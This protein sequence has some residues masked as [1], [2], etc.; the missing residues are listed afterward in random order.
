MEK[1]DSVDILEVRITIAAR[2]ET[3]FQ[4]LSDP[5]AFEQ[6]MGAGSSLGKGTGAP[7]RV[8]YPNGDVAA[9]VIEESIPNQRVVMSWGY[10]NGIN[11]IPVGA[12]RVEITLT[13]QHGNTQVVLRQSGLR[14][15]EQRR[16]HRAGWRYYLASL[17]QLASSSLDGVIENAIGTY[18]EAWA[19]HDPST[20]SELLNRCMA[21]GGVFRDAMGY[22]EG[23]TDLND[24]IGAARQ[25]APGIAMKRDGPLSRSQ[26]FVAYRW[27]MVAP[28]DTT[29][30]TGSNTV[31]FNGDGLI[32][33]VTGFWDR[34]VN[35]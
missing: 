7:F 28:D 33:S 23:I 34:P 1:S 22:A 19:V 3:V 31:E 13:P 2:P 8:A 14:N 16:N 15:A 10:E 11:N 30:M 35:A 25:F 12:T 9:G 17:S 5:A 21:H 27:K 24:Y 29:V 18:T 26:G 4:F 32:Q 20:R 6:W